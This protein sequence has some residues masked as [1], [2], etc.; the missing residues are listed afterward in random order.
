MMIKTSK[1]KWKRFKKTLRRME[2]KVSMELLEARK[3][4]RL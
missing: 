1:K 3:Q 4:L 2:N